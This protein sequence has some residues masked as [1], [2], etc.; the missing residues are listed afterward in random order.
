MWN[1]IE[2]A[3]GEDLV[4]WF[5]GELKCCASCGLSKIHRIIVKEN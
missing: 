2:G 4:E 1:C 3:S 5:Y